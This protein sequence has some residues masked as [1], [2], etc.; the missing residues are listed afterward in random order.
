MTFMAFLEKKTMKSKLLLLAMITFW[1]LIGCSPTTQ[2]T[3]VK[4]H[5]STL[6]TEPLVQKN[7]VVIE[8]TKPYCPWGSPCMN[9]LEPGI[10]VF[11]GEYLIEGDDLDSE[12]NVETYDA[13]KEAANC[14]RFKGAE[15]VRCFANYIMQ[16]QQ[17]PNDNRFTEQWHHGPIRSV[18]AW[19]KLGT[20]QSPLT[21]AV[22]DTGVDCGH[23]DL[24]CLTGFNTWP[25]DPH[26][27]D[28]LHGHGTHVAGAASATINNN[29][30][31]AGIA[32][33]RIMPVR[34]LNYQGA[35]TLAQVM[36]G[37]RW[38]RKKRA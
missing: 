7:E 13:T 29:V 19:T 18:D 20:Y 37:Y 14:D 4:P 26:D 10:Y 16:I 38:A 36:K 21:I 30:G 32:N 22:L 35:G 24:V 6:A 2:D 33:G 25:G 15:G 9:P 27:V 34:V 31:I 11:K 3:L 1:G 28:D 8:V 12:I 17:T 5:F 23:S